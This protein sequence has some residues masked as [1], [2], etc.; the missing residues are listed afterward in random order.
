M[1]AAVIACGDASPVRELGEPVLDLVALAVDRFVIF[2]RLLAVFYR[3]DTGGGALLGQAMAEPV[4]VVVAAIGDQRAACGMRGRSAR[5]PPLWSLTCPAV[6]C[7]KIGFPASS[8]TAC[9]LKFRP[10]SVR[11][12][13]REKCLVPSFGAHPGGQDHLRALGAHHRL[14][15]VGLAV[16]MR[17]R[18]AHQRAVRIGQIGL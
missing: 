16:F 12:R 9:S 17:L 18:A 3:W 6:R 5:A 15:V 1:G 7:S 8:Q 14:G 2:Q 4:T 10:P 13:Q 11:P